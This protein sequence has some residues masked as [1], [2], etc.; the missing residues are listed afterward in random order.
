MEHLGQA[1][2]Q[3]Y[4]DGEMDE[5]LCRRIKAHLDECPQCREQHR[6][7]QTIHARVAESAPPSSAFCSDGAFWLQLAGQL[8]ERRKPSW[9]LVPYLP[10]VVLGISAGLVQML[11]SIAVLAQTLMGLGLIPSLGASAGPRLAGWLSHPQLQA[12]LSDS[13][14]VSGAQ[15]ANRLVEGY[16]G[17]G[18]STQDALIVIGV[19]AVLGVILAILVALFFYWASCW[20]E[21]I[22][23]RLHRRS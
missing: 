20:S 12:F 18:S 3:C 22:H 14:G 7:W 11:V 6:L 2:L 9:P 4:L 13:F 21:S 16:N 1:E 8:D 15:V 17:I 19:V 10:P 23:H 5:A